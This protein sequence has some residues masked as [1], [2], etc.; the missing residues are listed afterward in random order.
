LLMCAGIGSPGTLA[1]VFR[2]YRGDRQAPQLINDDEI[3]R[4]TPLPPLKGEFFKLAGG[5]G[6][7]RPFE[8]ATLRLR[9]MAEVLS[10]WKT[11]VPDATYLTQRGATFLFDANGQLLYSHRDRAILGFAANMSRPLSFLTE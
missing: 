9:N 7:Q 8:L 4:A 3:V 1:E 5:T 2:G 6:F 11:Y 10:H